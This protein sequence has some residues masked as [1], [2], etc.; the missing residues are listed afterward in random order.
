MPQWLCQP[1]GL[2]CFQMDGFVC[3]GVMSGVIVEAPRS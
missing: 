1:L 3:A 2:F